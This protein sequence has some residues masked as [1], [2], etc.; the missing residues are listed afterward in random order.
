MTGNRYE[1]AISETQSVVDE[2]LTG[3]PAALKEPLARA[4]VDRL[5]AKGVIQSTDPDDLTTQYRTGPL[6]PGRK[7]VGGER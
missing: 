4:I 5:V 3:L 7:I 2:W 6:A 1:T